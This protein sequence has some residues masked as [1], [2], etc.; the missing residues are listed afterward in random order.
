M[1]SFGRK[2]KSTAEASNEALLS[3]K[4]RSD[5]LDDASGIGLWD[6]YLHE[7]DAAHSQSRWTWS[8]EFR[9]LVGFD[10]EASFPNLMT[11]W[12]DRLHPDDVEQ[13]FA[14]FGRCVSD[15]SGKTGYDVR[16]RL[17]VKDGSYRWFRATGGARTQSDGR[18]IL[19]CGS[20][21]D[22]HEEMLLRESAEKAARDS[23][24]TLAVLSR[25]LTAMAE[26]DL[27]YRVTEELPAATASLGNNFNDALGKLQTMVAH[28]LETIDSMVAET[29]EIRRAAADLASRTEQQAASLEETSASMGEFT[30]AVKASAETA[31]RMAVAARETAKST[32]ESEKVVSEAISAMAAIEAS[33]EKVSNIIGVID[34]IAFQ[35]N[36]LALNAGVEAAR[37][38]EAGKGFAVVA[39]EVRA[40]AQRSAEA[41][42]EIKS[43]ISSSSE[44]VEGGVNLVGRTAA[45]LQKIAE[46]I[47]ELDTGLTGLAAG[48]R[49]QASTVAEV[50]HSVQQMDGMTQQ[51]AAM[52][53]E[54]SAA[55]RSL[56]DNMQML[57]ELVS[58][59]KVGE[60]AAK[61]APQMEH[62]RAA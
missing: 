9:R 40:L 48:A 58:A 17:K 35:T 29:G 39:Q 19:A 16:Y 4:R 53:E 27:T 13:V 42:K 30:T 59:F 28:L 43:L 8:A 21:T 26:G 6:A 45:E 62:R 7:G 25:A 3:A 23:E 1:L 18:T 38:G 31:D 14:A 61:R 55:T 12:S 47:L 49:Q 57:H 41:A 11:S 24:R 22:V 34:E 37:A 54:T 56:E 46:R 32:T 60:R 15:K 2:D 50:G 52:V 44:Q 20:L 5:L 10:T 33:S 36:L 51:N